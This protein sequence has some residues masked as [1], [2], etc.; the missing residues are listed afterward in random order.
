[1]A[2]KKQATKKEVKVTTELNDS[3]DKVKETVTKVNEQI[4][5]TTTQVAKDLYAAGEQLVE[6]ARTNVKE[7][8]AKINLEDGYNAVKDIAAKANKYAAD[9]AEELVD[10]A[11]STSETWQKIT[12]KAI[13]GGLNMAAKNQDIVFNTLEGVKEQILTG[14][15]RTRALFKK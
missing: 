10:G 3:F 15:K 5:E 13:K 6:N 14:T 1:M 11:I 4:T 9:T 8:V 2:T 7:T 12:A